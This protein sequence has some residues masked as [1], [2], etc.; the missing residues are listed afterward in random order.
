MS[1]TKTDSWQRELEENYKA[2]EKLMP[3]FRAQD[4]GKFV[5]MRN[6]K[7]VNIFDSAKDAVIFAEAQFPDGMYSVQQVTSKVVDLGYFSHAV[8]DRSV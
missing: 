3:N 6:G 2:F 7:Q 8:P 4:N 5:L 1:T